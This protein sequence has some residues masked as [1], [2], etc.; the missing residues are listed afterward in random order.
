MANQTGLFYYGP[1]DQLWYGSLKLDIF[2]L[3]SC[4]LYADKFSLMPLVNEPCKSDYRL[5]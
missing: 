1:K 2:W 3:F 5:L 4:K